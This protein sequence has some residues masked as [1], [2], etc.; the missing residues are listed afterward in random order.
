MIFFFFNYL[1]NY[2]Y[3]LKCSL[4][5]EIRSRWNYNTQKYIHEKKRENNRNDKP[6]KKNPEFPSNSEPKQSIFIFV[7][8][9]WST[10]HLSLTECTAEAA[11]AAVVAVIHQ[12]LLH[13]SSIGEVA[14]RLLNPP[15]FTQD[16]IRC[17]ATTV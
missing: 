9:C 17:T 11:T 5:R 7:M 6:D 2:I 15:L 3:N 16:R 8:M 1:L 10:N 12:L 4:F 13:V 14:G